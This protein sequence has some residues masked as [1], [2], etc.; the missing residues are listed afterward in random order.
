MK[1]LIA[2]ILILA[3]AV[4]ATTIADAYNEPSSDYAR[5]NKSVIPDGAVFVNPGTYISGIDIPIGNYRIDAD[6]Y[7][8]YIKYDYP[9]IDNAYNLYFGKNFGLTTIS[10]F[11]VVEG[12]TVRIDH[13]GVYFSQSDFN[14]ITA[15][16]FTLYPGLYFPGKD[17]PAGPYFVEKSEYEATLYQKKIKWPHSNVFIGDISNKTKL[18]C[19][20]D[21]FICILYF[22]VVFS[23]YSSPFFE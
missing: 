11:P 4:P 9:G 10:Y 22:P 3:L 14:T 19:T 1:R 7:G 16:Q 12:S 6:C 21:T 15:D 20:D 13:N 5:A 8:C 2:I 17:F 18:D 23:E